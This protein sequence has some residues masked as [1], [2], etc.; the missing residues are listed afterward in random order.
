VPQFSDMADFCAGSPWLDQML[1]G[2]SSSHRGA[3]LARADI[4]DLYQL[5]HK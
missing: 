1:A 5:L 3:P 2:G 4:V